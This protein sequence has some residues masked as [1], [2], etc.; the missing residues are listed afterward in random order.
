MTF[1]RLS[2][3]NAKDFSLGLSAT[4]PR[5]SIKHYVAQLRIKHYVA[6]APSNAL[7]HSWPAPSS[8]PRVAAGRLPSG[9]AVVLRIEPPAASRPLRASILPSLRSA[10]AFAVPATKT[11]LWGSGLPG[12]GSWP[13]TPWEQWGRPSGLWTPLL[14]GLR[15]RSLDPRQG[16]A[17][18][19]GVARVLAALR[20]APATPTAL[21]P[22]LSPTAEH[23]PGRC[24]ANALLVGI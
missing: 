24:P 19:F 16:C 15:L 9:R 21:D 17:A 10:D 6:I 18:P 23:R 2:Q 1:D 3:Q 11:P 5:G 20:A 8:S 4:P 13:H 7:L 14:H 22:A 12:V